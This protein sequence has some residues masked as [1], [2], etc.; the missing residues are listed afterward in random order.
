M[1]KENNQNAFAVIGLLFGAV[2]WGFIWYPYR[3]LNEAGISGVVSSLYT[4]AIAFA[5]GCVI[6]AN[7]F[8]LPFKLEKSVCLLAMAA[9]WTNLSYVLAIIDGQVMRV[10]LL[11]YLSPIWT[12]IFAHFWLK[13]RTTLIAITVVA[14]ALTGAIIMLWQAKSLPIP[15]STAEWLGLSSGIGFSLTN[16]LTRKFTHLT[17]A[18]K[19]FSVWIGVVFVSL[20][21][22][23]SIDKNT[24]D[25]ILSNE[26]VSYHE[27]GLLILV[28]MLLMAATV[29][30][31]Y[32]V[33]KISAM[34]ASVLF[35]FELVV[36]AIASY[37]LANE[38]ME[39]Q[40]WFGGTLIVF[41]AFLASRK[42]N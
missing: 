27:I 13:E 39:V 37:F 30:V 5:F 15:Q 28:A 41:A 26:E 29:C 4:Y 16:V 21:Y 18:E 10:I 33:T 2:V 7:R 35:M 17:L 11:F 24:A 22:L 14:I 8:S 25:L 31:Q 42:V 36:A 38:V 19:S 20:I 1:V 34:S 9:G 6:F 3:L 23:M 32:G 12:I 40:E